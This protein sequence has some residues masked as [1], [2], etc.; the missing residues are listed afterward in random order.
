MDPS[1]KNYKEKT[2]VTAILQNPGGLY[3]PKKL[4]PKTDI[5]LVMINMPDKGKDTFIY[6]DDMIKAL[7]DRC[8]IQIGP[9]KFQ[10]LPNAGSAAGSESS[11]APFTHSN[12]GTN[13]DSC[14]YYPG[15][16]EGVDH[17]K[18]SVEGQYTDIVKKVREE[19]YSSSDA[20]EAQ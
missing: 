7:Q 14:Q 2:K 16:P 20:Q 18:Q 11:R 17:C 15:L 6:P 19:I 13:K 5:G 9:N 8:A 4:I 1:M 12:V 10:F 3:P